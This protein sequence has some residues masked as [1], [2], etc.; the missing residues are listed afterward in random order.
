[1]A[2]MR[3]ERVGDATLYLGDCREILPALGK[4]DAVVT[5]PPYGIEFSYESYDDTLENWLELVPPIV[6][7]ARKI[8]PFVVLPC[9]SISRLGWWYREQPPDWL[10]SW[11]QAGAPARHSKIGF[12]TWQALVCFG[13]PAVAMHDYF[14]TTDT[15]IANGHTCPKPDGFSMWLCKRA[16]QSCGTILDPFMGSG[17]TGVACANL[18]RKF[19]GIEIE[20]KYFDIAC[21]RIERA[22]AQPRLFKDEAPEPKQEAFAL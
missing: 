18:G 20:P 4:V 14:S 2:E 15:P 8:A 22:Y 9:C 6:R 13:R 5:D 7:E 3:I 12:N 16:A 10:I 11:Y 19:I 21:K 17:T 1:M